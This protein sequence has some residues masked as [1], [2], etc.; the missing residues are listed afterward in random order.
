[1]GLCEEIT[2]YVT[3]VPRCICTFPVLTVT[4]PLVS[5]IIGAIAALTQLATGLPGPLGSVASLISRDD[6]LLEDLVKRQAL[7]IGLNGL[8]TADLLKTVTGATSSL[9]LGSNPLAALQ[10]L[11]KALPVPLPAGLPNFSANPLAVLSGLTNSLPLPALGGTPLAAV[12]GLTNNLPL[13]ALG[14]NPLSAV[15]GLTS[16]LSLPVGNHLSLASGLTNN[17]PVAN[18]A[19]SLLNGGDGPLSAVKGLTGNLPTPGLSGGLA[20]VSTALP[21]GVNTA[22]VTALVTNLLKNLPNAQT[23]SDPAQAVAGIVNTV[24]SL[25]PA[26]LNTIQTVTPTLSALGPLS[27]AIQLLPLADPTKFSALQGL[28]GLDAIKSAVGSLAPDQ[29]N[30]LKALPL[31]SGAAANPL[32]VVNA[33]LGGVI[34][35]TGNGI[36]IR[37]L[38]PCSYAASAFLL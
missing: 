11:N 2:D 30:L 13:P 33:V 3:P 7:P 20:D 12:S 14:A 37:L 10:G 31:P 24:S 22:A 36:G 35:A 23:L 9:P 26:V 1:M 4:D 5:T 34:A 18:V 6:P 25:A 19:T 17:P 27:A 32:A 38:V 16:K 21:G 29:L 15:S 28:T 8:P